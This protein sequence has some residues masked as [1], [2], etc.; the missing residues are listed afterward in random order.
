MVRTELLRAKSL[1]AEVHYLKDLQKVGD[2]KRHHDQHS[3]VLKD[4]ENQFWKEAV[5]GQG[6]VTHSQAPTPSTAQQTAS[7]LDRIWRAHS[8]LKEAHQKRE[9][10][11]K[12]LQE[13]LATLSTSKQRIDSLQ[14][15]VSKAEKLRANRVESRM[16]E[17][18]AELVGTTRAI[19]DLRGRFEESQISSS[20]T[21]QSLPFLTNAASSDQSPK[22]TALQQSV[23]DISSLLA[24]STADTPRVPATP[25]SIPVPNALQTQTLQP[26]LVQAPVVLR[27]EPASIRAIEASGPIAAPL[28]IGHVEFHRHESH[29]ALTISASIGSAPPVNLVITKGEGSGLKVVVDPG[30]SGLA[31]QL[32]RDK[33][34]LQSRLQALGIKVTSLEVGSADGSPQQARRNS[35]KALMDPDEEL[36]A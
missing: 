14:K 5:K 15:L 1:H 27:T 23:V 7:Q 22:G 24:A 6:K 16:S 18:V 8:Q 9:S 20:V 33:S 32:S 13:G 10:S 19:A 21:S 26:Q 11:A 36:I 4:K 29:S 30:V 3:K 28:Q 12:K 34:V 31:G 2:I 25:I 35:R 17:E